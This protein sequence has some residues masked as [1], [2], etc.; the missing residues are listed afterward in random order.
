M[1]QND[2][3]R[4]GEKLSKCCRVR[5]AS[6]SHAPSPSSFRIIRDLLTALPYHCFCRAVTRSPI[7]GRCVGRPCPGTT[8]DLCLWRGGEGAEG[9]GGAEGV[10]VGAD[11]V[12]RGGNTWY[13][14]RPAITA[15]A[16]HYSARIEAAARTRPADRRT[17]RAKR[18]PYDSSRTEECY[19]AWPRARGTLE[20]KTCERCSLAC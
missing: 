13:C 12:R 10:L 9:G 8:P 16:S 15:P 7:S 11:M 2:V 3:R 6:P 20:L 19:L 5:H 14:A 17:L 4:R 1:R 18:T